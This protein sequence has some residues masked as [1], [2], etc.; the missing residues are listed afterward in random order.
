MMK[1]VLI[2]EDDRDM[3]EEM[4]EILLD[5]KYSVE[6][7]FNGIRGEKLIND[8]NF[9]IIL[10]DLK[11]PGINGIDLLKKIKTKNS[12]TKVIVLTGRPLL[13]KFFQEDGFFSDREAKV[14]DLADDII[15]KPFDVKVVLD[16]I[17]RLTTI[18]E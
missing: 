13:S 10:L 5:E 15:N 14:L 16:K 6:L 7:A 3:C 18:T 11:L 1:K 9:D 4:M 17:K 2:I 8:A 12:G